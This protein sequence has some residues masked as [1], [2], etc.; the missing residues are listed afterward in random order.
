MPRVLIY[1]GMV[2]WHGECLPSYYYYFKELG[3]DV[4]FAIADTAIHKS[5]L[6]MIKDPNTKIYMFKNGASPKKVK[7][8]LHLTELKKKIPNLLKYDLYFI[9]TLVPATFEFARYLY[10]YNHNYR[11]KV[12]FQCH[13]N[14]TMFSKWM[15]G[16]KVF[17]LNGFTL[18]LVTDKYF[19]QLPPIKSI[20]GFEHKE[21]AENIKKET[22]ISLF[23]GGLSHIHFKN[24]EKL[25]Q[26]VEE[27]NKEGY[28]II[29]NVTGVRE[30]GDYILPKSK[31]VNYLGKLLFEDMTYQYISNTFLFVLFDEKPFS[32][33]KDHHEFL[34]GRVSGSRNMSI[35]Y[36]IPLVVQKPFQKS[37][38][39][40]NTNSIAYEGHD[41][42]QVLLQL[43]KL[44]SN[45]YNTIV[46]NLIQKEKEEFQLGL[47][48]LKNKIN[49]ITSLPET[50]STVKSALDKPIKKDKFLR[51]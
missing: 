38:G 47:N 12:I 41:Y 45:Q 23:I 30:L 42:K 44:D 4:D 18:G 29:V 48:N 39:L 24:F 28:N 49:L 36:N 21:I 14:Y 19:P 33:S 26:A 22:P 1:E 3:Y 46:N 11:N 7:A 31:F 17:N 6:W 43:Y 5:A 13:R 40:D 15:N 34:S 32:C 37:W 20:K 10:K 16:N 8:N 50:K 9:S 27:L 51:F 35:M 25:V 2:N